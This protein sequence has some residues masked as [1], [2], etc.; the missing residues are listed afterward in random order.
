MRLEG[1]DPFEP[2][3][4]EFYGGSA[5]EIYRARLRDCLRSDIQAATSPLY[6]IMAAAR[7]VTLLKGYSPTA[8][9]KYPLD[10]YTAVT[11]RIVA[12][13]IL[14][15]RIFPEDANG[16]PLADVS[17]TLRRSVLKRRSNT[18]DGVDQPA[19]IDLTCR[20]WLGMIGAS[21]PGMQPR[22]APATRE[23]AAPSGCT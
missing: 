3:M 23:M 11:D 18:R 19:P 17:S 7:L 20:G 8:T 2:L 22:T 4:E 16:G 15:D 13:N 14:D 12:L 21:V 5:G 9:T 6:I 10:V 1:H